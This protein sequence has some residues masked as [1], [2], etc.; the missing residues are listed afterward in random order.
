LF[1]CRNDRNITVSISFGMGLP[2]SECTTLPQGYSKSNAREILIGANQT[3]TT[4]IME[5]ASERIKE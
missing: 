5:L 2:D 4:D 1:S 3:R